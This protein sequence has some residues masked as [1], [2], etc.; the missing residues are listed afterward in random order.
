MY[1]GWPLF[2]SLGATLMAVDEEQISYKTGADDD[3]PDIYSTNWCYQTFTTTTAFDLSTIRLLLYSNGSPGT[4]TTYLE[5][6][7]GGEPSNTILATGSVVGTSIPAAIT[8]TWTTFTMTTYAFT[9][10]T[11]YAIVVKCS[12]SAASH[13]VWR[14][15]TSAPSYAGGEFGYST[16]SGTNWTAGNP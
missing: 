16:D 2:D 9:A 3:S 13:V 11:Q 12:G 5:S 15:D 7:A 10:L 14:V 4:V 6:V 1:I 8:G